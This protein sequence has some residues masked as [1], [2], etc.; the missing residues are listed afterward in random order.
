MPSHPPNLFDA[1]S[2]SFPVLSFICTASNPCQISERPQQMVQS[3]A[4]LQHTYLFICVAPPCRAVFCSCHGV[5]LRLP[6]GRLTSFQSASSSSPA[7]RRN[8]LRVVGL[9]ALGKQAEDW[10]TDPSAGWPHH[11]RRV[12]IGVKCNRTVPT[13]CAGLQNIGL[14]GSSRATLTVMR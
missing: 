4:L 5:L 3:M 6:E 10:T 13:W 12:S 9:Q 11:S 2:F 14:G 8:K 7:G 1:K